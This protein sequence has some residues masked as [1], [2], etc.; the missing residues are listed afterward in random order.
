MEGLNFLSLR[1]DLWSISQIDVLIWV[2]LSS[3]L[4]HCEYNSFL[5]IFRTDIFGLFKNSLTVIRVWWKNDTSYQQWAVKFFTGMWWAGVDEDNYLWDGNDGKGGPGKALVRVQVHTAAG[6]NSDGQDSGIVGGV[7][8]GEW[9]GNRRN[10][11]REQEEM[12]KGYRW[13]RQRKQK[14]RKLKWEG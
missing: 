1:F 4:C 8:D 5:L 9:W 3:S 13:G 11:G 2:I 12:R 7:G 14:T 10:D 6:I